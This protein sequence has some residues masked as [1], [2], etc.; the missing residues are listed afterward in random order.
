MFLVRAATVP[1][2]CSTTSN[3]G[4][5]CVTAVSRASSAKSSNDPSAVRTGVPRS[6]WIPQAPSPLVFRAY[7]RDETHSLKTDGMPENAATLT[8]YV[9]RE[10]NPSFFSMS[11]VSQMSTLSSQAPPRRCLRTFASLVLRGRVRVSCGKVRGKV[12]V[13]RDFEEIHNENGSNTPTLANSL[14]CTT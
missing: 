13:L 10:T 11:H 1:G 8:L 7:M 4:P 5:R 14:T 9:S 12:R 2:R 6:A 3:D